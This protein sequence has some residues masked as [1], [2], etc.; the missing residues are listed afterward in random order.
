ML[1]AVPPA[2]L[3]RRHRRLI[4]AWLAVVVLAANLLVGGL[5]P[6]AWGDGMVVCTADGLRVVGPD[7]TARPASGDAHDVCLLCLPVAH[8]GLH[9]P[10]VPPT[11]VLPAEP[12]GARWPLILDFGGR[13]R[14]AVLPG[15][16]RAPPSV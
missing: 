4:S 12:S 3:P 8:G 14:A 15:L 2:P 7:G 10:P 6:S 9:L 11:L 13:R 1:P 16:A 5:A